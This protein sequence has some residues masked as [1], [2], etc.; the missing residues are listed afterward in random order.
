MDD[1]RYLE[2]AQQAHAFLQRH[3]RTADSAFW[4]AG[5]QEKRP[6]QGNWMIMPITPG[7]CLNCTIQPLIFPILTKR[8]RL[9]QRWFIPFST[10]K[11]GGFYFYA[12]DAEQLLTRP[13]EFYDGALPSGN[14]VAT[15]VLVRLAALTNEPDWRTYADSSASFSRREYCRFFHGAL[16]CTFG[17]GRGLRSAKEPLMFY[18]WFCPVRGPT[19]FFESNLSISW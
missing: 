10:T 18:R 19:V 11:H 17:V 16:F 5:G 7:H 3:L 8:L 6:I 9:P 4:C 1:V 2:A 12:S 13:K 15:L 14:A